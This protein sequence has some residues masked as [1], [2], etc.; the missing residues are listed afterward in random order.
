MINC[1]RR[2][3]SWHV[4]VGL[5]VLLCADSG[6]FAQCPKRCRGISEQNG[7]LCSFG[8]DCDTGVC[9]ALPQCVHLEW[10]PSQ[11]AV[12]P[13]EIVEVGLYAVS[14]SGFNQLIQAMD[15]ILNWDS[16]KLEIMDVVD[17]C[18]TCDIFSVNTGVL[19]TDDSDCTGGA[20]GQPDQCFVCPANTYN[21]F[22]SGFLVDCNADKL[23][24]PCTGP[25]PDNDGDA[26][27][28]A[29]AQII[30]G[31]G[32]PI[33]ALA[34]PAGL[35]VTTFQFRVIST[36]GETLLDILPTFGA[37][38]HTRIIGGSAAGDQILGL[39]DPAASIDV[40]PNCLPSTVETAGCRYLNVTPPAGTDPVA[41]LITGDLGD[42]DV[43]CIS[44]Y[45]QAA[46]PKGLSAVGPTAVYQTPAQWGTVSVFGHEIVP[47]KTYSVFT[48]CGTTPGSV[49]ALPDSATTWKWGDVNNDTRANIADIL[50]VVDAFLGVFVRRATP[51]TSDAQCQ[52]PILDHPHF[53]CDTIEGFCVSGT[54]GSLDLMSPDI[55]TFGC[56]P[57]G[58]V[59]IADVLRSVDAFLGSFFPCNMPCP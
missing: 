51:C 35:L 32:D 42:A 37:F 40:V 30:C 28:T 12:A 49:L 7:N 13:D 11:Q 9:E 50:R 46:G 16:T 33:P 57:D 45:V 26:L 4:L 48:D 41:L 23:N 34:T 2:V 6:V 20:C 44:V 56:L 39:V 18:R 55:F 25:I 5:F 36:S 1:R 29:I 47:L 8:A 53:K 27:F 52:D 14:S 24:F 15:V 59:N 10:R 54:I 43:S 17:A 3:A 31:D 38:S 22:T 58:V 19:C 21:W